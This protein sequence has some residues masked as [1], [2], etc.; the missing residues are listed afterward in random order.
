[1]ETTL[2]PLTLGEILDRTAELYRNNFVLFAGIFAPYAGVA[3]VLNLIL[4]GLGMLLKNLHVA[5]ATI[6]ITLGAGA[7]EMLV[8]F[9]LFGASVAAICC[10]VAW[11]HLGRAATIRGA[12]ATVLPRLGRYLWLMTI[13]A[14]VVWT[15][16]VLLYIGF[17]GILGFYGKVF[18]VHPGAAP[19]PPDPQSAIIIGVSALV[20]FLLLLPIGAYTIF[21]SL[22]YALALPACVVENNTARASLQR[23]VHLSK[24]ARGR[25]FVLALLIGV[26]KFGLVGITHIFTI[27]GV[28]KNHGQ[29]GPGLTAISQIIEFFTTTFL[30]P[31]YATGITLLYYDQRVRKEGF[32]IEWMMQAAG[33]TAP[34]PI[35]IE[36]PQSGA[37]PPRNPA[38]FPNE[39]P[40]EPAP[41]AEPPA[42]PAPIG[43]AQPP[44]YPGPSHPE[45]SA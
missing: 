27:V 23:A 21:M 18:S 15:P 44:P 39:T 8:L 33:L 28:V 30:G 38:A 31:I 22:R 24:G 2:R 17:F 34:A 20:F 16:F 29:L 11:V 41:A 26:I 6:W 1:M 3:L 35:E 5:G 19:A 7:L 42:N 14:F 10:A 32:D 25:I 36:G 45:P 4:I 12:Y 43:A 37:D 40:P 13:T 9:L